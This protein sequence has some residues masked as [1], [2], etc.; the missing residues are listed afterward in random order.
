MAPRDWLDLA[1]R[2]TGL[3]FIVFA[4]FDVFFAVTKVF[5]IQTGSSAALSADILAAIYYTGMGIVILWYAP[6][7]V[8]L[9]FW[10]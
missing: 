9:A 3:M 5:G 4:I 10:R 7:I 1:V 8:H 6:W 2:M